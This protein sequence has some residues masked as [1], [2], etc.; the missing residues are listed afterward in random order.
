MRDRP[1]I[2]CEVLPR[3]HRNRRTQDIVAAL[4]YQPYWITPTGYIRVPD[5]DF[6]RGQLTD[7]LLS[8]VST[9]DIVVGD[10]SV[11]VELKQEATRAR[12]RFA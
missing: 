11:L 1:F 9:P 10:L 6:Q 5:F 8:P 3:S 12:N 4:D 7:F 2:V